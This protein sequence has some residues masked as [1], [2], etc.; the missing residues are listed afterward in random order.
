MF[1]L[2]DFN[3]LHSAIDFDKP[4]FADTETDGL[5]GRVELVQCMQ[6]GW[7]EVLMCRRPEA[8]EVLMLFKYHVVMHNT[9]YDVTTVQQTILKSFIPKNFDDTLLLSRIAWPDKETYT[10]D[11]V[12]FYTLGFD[13]YVKAGLNKK[14]L[15]KS[16]WSA[17]KLSDDQLLYAALDVWHMPAVWE[18]CKAAREDFNYKLDMATLRHCFEFQWVGM[19]VNKSKWYEFKNAIENKVAN[20]ACPINVNSYQQVRKYIGESSSDDEAL[21]LFASKGNEKAAEV[22][23]VRKDKKL[24]SFLEKFKTERIFGK[25]AP[26]A[27]SGRM[28]CKDQNLQQIPRAL[29]GVFGYEPNCGRVLIYADYAQLELR[30]I[31]AIVR[32]TAMEKLFREGE[33]LHGFTAQMIYGEGWTKKDRQTAKGYNFCLLYGGG[34][35]MVITYMLKTMGIS[36]EEGQVNRDRRRWRNL[37]REI[38]AWQEQGIRNFQVGRLGSTPFGRKYKAKMMTDQLN[39]ENQ[40]AGADVTKLAL[41]YFS[42]R[43]NEDTLLADVHICNVIHDSFIL[44]APE[45]LEVY[46]YASLVLAECMQEAWFEASKSFAIKDLPM[47]VKIAVDY[48]WADCDN[49]EITHI[50]D[51]KL[52]P[53]RM[54][55]KV[56]A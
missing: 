34:I 42:Q 47:P 12:L 10:L 32:C 7:P 20:A 55:E 46:E 31:C 19:P 2:V 49:D 35:N 15:Q 17:A 16:K 27:R 50:F 37:W 54:L 23:R 3:T 25:F 18:A 44:D 52:E 13:P 38:F 14:I 36:L 6:E 39:I 41:H 1:K 22:K 21:S 11:D 33:D 45:T 30:T 26:A 43:K 9:H 24:L 40:G 48:N 29:K 28:T 8:H 4:L 53:Y 56:N 5:Y 51:Y